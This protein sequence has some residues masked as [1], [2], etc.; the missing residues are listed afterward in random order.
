MA[1][2]GRILAAIAVFLLLAVIVWF[3]YDTLRERSVAEK[4]A[5]IIHAEDQRY[6]SRA[7]EHYLADDS[8]T[9]RARAAL[10]VG[11]IDD[12]RSG[13][14]LAA[15]LRDESID[16]ASNAAFAM[17]LTGD[18]DLAM[19]LLDIAND[20]PSAVTARAVESAGR[21]ADSSQTAVGA[22]LLGYLSHPS[23]DVREAACYALFRAG[24]KTHA[25]ELI[26]F[27][28]SE[29]DSL[30]RI[31]ALYS[32]ARL[33]I[34]GAQS[35]FA[36]YQAESDPYTRTLAVRGL[37]AARTEEAARLL[38]L[39]LNDSDQRVV[40]QAIAGLQSVATPSAAQYLARKLTGTTD[41]NL[42]VALLGALENLKSNLG[43]AS[44]RTQFTSRLS[45]NL[46]AASLTYLATI[47]GD[48][49][50]ATVDSLLTSTPTAR[51]RAACADAYAKV[52]HQ[53]IIPRLAVLFADE[54]PLVR[55]S[56]FTALMSVDSANA[57]F[58]I[59]RA[60]ADRD[61]MPVVLAIDQVGER[62][63]TKYLPD[64]LAFMRGGVDID[65]DIRRSSVD[66][67]GVMYDPGVHPADADSL[68]LAVMIAGIL[69]PEYVVRRQA[70]TVY[71]DKFGEDRFDD[72]TLAETR[73]SES[74]LREAI[75]S[76]EAA[77]N[78]TALILTSKGEI[79][80]ELYVDV[81]PLTVLNFIELAKDDFY[82]GLIFHRVVPN[83]V[84][85]GGDPRGDGWGGPPWFIRCEYSDEPFLR[86]TV[87]IATSG[88][89]TGGSQFFITHSPQPHLDARYTVFGQVV[90]GMEVVDQITPG[91][92]IE[93]III[94]E[95]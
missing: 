27:I 53:S 94:Q 15:M 90:A 75:E 46:V 55:G 5:T 41:E 57:G 18:R 3:A 61:F 21:L 87:G 9:V 20:L 17:G 91:D 39:S 25:Q 23:P 40:A 47:E 12:P 6:L 31:A 4:K 2:I 54:D 77:G 22:A 50:V 1:K 93:K 59:Q 19:Q 10:A 78:P 74:R 72:V 68:L 32:L 35:I 92:V 95:G 73:I 42:I 7:L 34:P 83:F 69:D 65:P 48:R 60:L 37:A 76:A 79:E 44:A 70:A 80:L 14:L 28:N 89:D 66:A 8:S 88:K 64:L 38:A 63:L 30:V 58:Y 62:K 16:V 36:R 56:A 45:D 29:P 51:V 52:N 49:V 13:E 26:S 86:G 33:Q 85:Q 43:V 71:R 82:A 11:R 81:A 24:A 67:A 84:A